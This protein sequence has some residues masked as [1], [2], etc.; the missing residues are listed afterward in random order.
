MT[1][2][3]PIMNQLKSFQMGASICCFFYLCVFGF[4]LIFAGFYFGKSTTE[5]VFCSQQ[6]FIYQHG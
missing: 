2:A 4:A 6:S 5:C 3:T 1:L